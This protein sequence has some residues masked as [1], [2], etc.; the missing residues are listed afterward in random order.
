MLRYDMS[1]SIAESHL[2]SV[3]FSQVLCV[4]KSKNN[5]LVYSYST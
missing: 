2:F 3:R 4:K 1:A 5:V